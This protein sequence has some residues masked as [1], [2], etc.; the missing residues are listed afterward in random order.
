[1]FTAN[2]PGSVCATQANP[3]SGL[4]RAAGV[5][6]L[7]NALPGLSVYLGRILVAREFLMVAPAT[8]RLDFVPTVNLSRVFLHRA[9]DALEAGRVFEAGVLLR[10]SVRR[11]LY[12]ECAWKGCLPTKPVK[13]RSPSAL[14]HALT[15]AGHVSYCGAEWTRE[16]I[17]LGNKCAHCIKVDPRDIRCS[18]EVWHASID[19]DPCGEPTERVQHMKPQAE[20]CDDCDDDD[21]ADW[22]KGG[23]A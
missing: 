8:P 15:E 7:T 5:L 6:P 20:V 17:E 12:A 22:W 14:L 18:I 9:A 1:M 21:G 23:A 11:Q 19:N 16:I 3:F 2:K 4:A 10:E 13:Q